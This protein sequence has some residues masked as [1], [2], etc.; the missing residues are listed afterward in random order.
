MQAGGHVVPDGHG[1]KR[2][3]ALEDHADVTADF[4]GV[5]AARVDVAAVEQ[6]FA[7]HARRGDRLVHPVEAPEQGRLAA[8]RRA[9]DGRDMTVEEIDA[10]A[11]HR[12][13]RSEVRVQL[14]D[15]DTHRGAG[16]RF[17]RR[18]RHPRANH[19]RQLSHRPH[20]SAIE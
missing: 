3:G 18:R 7:F 19:I 12:A 11:A 16:R 17:S 20:Q 9:D 14:A 13:Q 5:D 6:D 2:R 10:R 1:G 8:P 15:A 4:D